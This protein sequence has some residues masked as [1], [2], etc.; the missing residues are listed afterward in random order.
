MSTIT[1]PVGQLTDDSGALLTSGA[2]VTISSVTD[3]SGTAIPSHGATV[4]YAAPFCSVD[5]D[6]ETKGEAIITLAV[7]QSGRTITNGNASVSVYAARDSS[8][9]LAAIAGATG[10]V[11]L[12]SADEAVLSDLDTMITAQQF[13]GPALANTPTG[14]PAPT[15][16]EIVTGM[17]NTSTKLAS[18]VAALPTM[19]VTATVNDTGAT[20]TVFKGSAGLSVVNGFYVDQFL[21]FIG[22]SGLLPQARKI[23]GYIGSTRQFTFGT[24]FVGTPANG[25]PFLIAGDVA[26]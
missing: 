10:A 25:D 23:T 20:S 17:D 5:Y 7:S 24:A 1:Y 16:S 3:K 2:A 15:V 13:T 22:T 19:F 12:T 14:T 9:I 21:V 26:A 18:I 4:N 6:A 8:R 11:H